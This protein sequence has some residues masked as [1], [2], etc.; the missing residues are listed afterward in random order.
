MTFTLIHLSHVSL[1]HGLLVA[2]AKK[3][4]IIKAAYSN[5]VEWRGHHQPLAALPEALCLSLRCSVSRG[6]LGE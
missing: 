1:S 5:P 4:S 3:T 2:M 6:I